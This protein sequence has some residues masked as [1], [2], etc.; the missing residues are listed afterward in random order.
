MANKPIVV[1]VVRPGER[2]VLE[3]LDGSLESKQAI[4]DGSL[5]QIS[6]FEDDVVLLCNDEAK[7]FGAEL[8]RA[9]YD[10][11]GEMYDI[12]AGTFF[13]CYAPAD[14]DSYLSLPEDLIHKYA[15]L[16][17]CPESFYRNPLNG[18]I[19][20]LQDG[21]VNEYLGVNY[22]FHEH[23]DAID[24]EFFVDAENGID[25]I[26]IDWHSVPKDSDEYKDIHGVA[27]EWAGNLAIDRVKDALRRL[28]SQISIDER[29][30]NAT[31]RSEVDAA[32]QLAIDIL[33]LKDGSDFRFLRFSGLDWLEDG[34]NSV[35][36]KNYNHIYQYS[37]EGPVD[38]GNEAA[39]MDLLEKVYTR[40]NVRHPADFKGHS[41]SVSDV[42][43]LSKENQRKAFYCDSFGF[44]ELP[45][46]F[47]KD[48]VSLTIHD[49]TKEL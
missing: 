21:S 26:D 19:V 11:E 10:S 30:N 34:V 5:Q 7:L 40:F 43:V 27:K 44:A 29:L 31:V 20:R 8:N 33:Q 12:I 23:E 9:L 6:P 1:L 25:Y 24:I 45:E 35:L 38:F 2:P 39:V 3:A 37:D 4:V 18:S 16:F 28:E 46:K 15:N 32:G 41:L 14:S 22:L 36:C 42:V 13:V 47:V 49:A 48:F 17:E